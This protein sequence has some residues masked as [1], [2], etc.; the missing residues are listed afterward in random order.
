MSDIRNLEH[1]NA[2]LAALGEQLGAVDERYE[3]VVVGGSG[4]LA[5][6][7]I[8]RSTRDVDVVALRSGEELN[9]AKPLPEPLSRAAQ[10]VARDFDLDEAWLTAARP[11]CSTSGCP[12]ASSD[13]SRAA[14]TARP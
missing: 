10:R 13:D 14:T 2:V 7:E 8:E 5:L 1:A 9:G 4:L 12:R 11:T 6:G 3:L